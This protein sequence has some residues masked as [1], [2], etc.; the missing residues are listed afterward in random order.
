MSSL[1]AQAGAGSLGIGRERLRPDDHF[2]VLMETETSPMH[3]GALVLLDVPRDALPEAL[4][5]IRNQLLARLGG[6]PLLVR[7]EQS[8]EGYDSD[9]W[10][11]S[12][13][14][15]PEAFFVAE[16]DFLTT[17][18]LRQRVATL[19]LERLDLQGPPF[20]IWAFDNLDEGGVALYIKVHHARCDGIGFQNILG[21]FHDQSPAPTTMAA[22]API[23][24][25]SDWRLA[26]DAFFANSVEEREEKKRARRHAL[27]VLR[28]GELPERTTTPV[29]GL[30]GPVSQT[31]HYATSSIELARFKQVAHGVAATVNDLFLAIL[32]TALRRFLILLDDLPDTPLVVNASRSYR[33]EARHGLWG[34]RI[35][36]IHPHLATTIEDPLERLAAIQASMQ[37]ELQRSPFDE[38]LLDFPEEPYG[39]RDRREKF[40]A[41][42]A[43]GVAALPGNVTLSNVPGPAEQRSIA[44]F[45]QRAN[46]PV[47]ILGTGRFLNC[48]MRRNH[49]NLDL[50]LMVDGAKIDD[51][52][53]LLEWVAEAL[54]E[55]ERLTFA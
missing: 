33:D 40:A 42:T 48:T 30:S 39:A 41:R 22:P 7:L 43:A 28:S 23:L 6:T 25:E 14:L 17:A 49:T 12:G 32:A 1:S 8:P 31:R 19:A 51:P 13:P 38:A 3:I 11:D 16:S 36:A 5:K 27:E 45:V 15:E 18:D 53:R 2:M 46:Y 21:R 9:V 37:Q 29:F 35:V 34:N 20:R 44:G 50:G 10:V 52:E 54:E 4:A 24:S 26:S 55:Y 47:P